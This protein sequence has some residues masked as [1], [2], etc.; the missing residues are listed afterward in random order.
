MNNKFKQLLSDTTIFAIGNVLTK[1]ILFFLMPLYTSAMTTEQFGVAELLSN[2]VDLALP[3]VSLCIYDAVFRFAIDRDSDHRLLFTNGIKILFA[4]Y[5]IIFTGL[6]V[7]NFFI[8]YEYIWYFALMVFTEGLR[9]LSAQFIRGIGH[10][11]RFTAGG[12]LNALSLCIFNVIFLAVLNRGIEG[13]LISIILANI[14]SVVFI[15]FSSGIYKYISL[16]AEDNELLK[17]MLLFSLPQIPNLLSWWVI[18]LSS[19]YIIVG[20]LGAG[21]AGLF[22]AASK[23]PSVMNVLTGIF[24]QAWQF[25]SS[26]EIGSKDSGSFFSD[27]FKAYSVFIIVSCSGIIFFIPLISRVI[28]KGDFYEAWVYV[29]LLMVSAVLNGYSVYFGTFY[30]AVKKNRMIMISTMTGAAISLIICLAATPL[31]GVYGALLASIVS[32]LAIVIIRIIDTRKYVRIDIK[33]FINILSFVLLLLQA[34]VMTF[35]LPFAQAVSGGLFVLIAGCNI[36]YYQKDIK[37]IFLK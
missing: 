14:V 11:K 22:T 2:S 34:I 19:R 15:I 5:I 31:I 17:K 28:L 16:R 32:Y 30:I 12:V 6:A 4:S 1:L 9:R 35:N 3:V 23:L 27:V 26:K 10:T 7:A 37:M 13:Y 29:P 18:N 8:K 36:F 25:S 21:M 33:A 24:Q 20:F